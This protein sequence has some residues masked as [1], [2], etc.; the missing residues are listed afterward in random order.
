MEYSEQ[1]C[2]RFGRYAITSTFFGC[3]GEQLYAS[4][5]FFIL[6]M[7]MLG[8]SE[9]TA[10]F[11][12]SLKSW[13]LLLL[14]IP[15]AGLISRIGT[16]LAI[17]V[18]AFVVCGSFVLMA[19]AP[20]VGKY[21]QPLVL[22]GIFTYSLVNIL[23]SGAWYP[24]LSCFLKPAE[25]GSFFGKMR[26]Y[27]MFLNTAFIFVISCILDKKP[28]IWVMQLILLLVGLLYLGRKFCIDRMPSLPP[29]PHRYDLKKSLSISLR[30]TP[31][32]GF[33]FYICFYTLAGSMVIPLS[34][35]YMK[36]SLNFSE[37]TIMLVTTAWMAG[38]ICAYAVVG[39]LMK[40]MGHKWFQVLNHTITVV[41]VIG[42]CCAAPGMRFLVPLM[43]VSTFINGLC[44]AFSTCIFSVEMMASARPGNKVMAMAF[45]TT[46][47]SLGTA[48][49]RT[50]LTLILASGILCDKW[51]L[52]TMLM[53]KYQFL[54]LGVLVMLI[55][56]YLLL[57]LCPS[58]I[59]KH[60]D[61]YRPS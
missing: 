9:S 43:A 41:S 53:D 60:R 56:F 42:F 33:S 50:L 37:S 32:V 29:S 5:S 39:K 21:A 1:E 61:Y 35:L 10:M 18:D 34:V 11:S 38:F 17:A 3:L 49:G 36:T 31:L 15:A 13:A 45:C 20:F 51:M 57:L 58:V 59:S 7:V 25:R 24:V 48:I 47:S 12:T 27:Y 54:L 16:K 44:G 40:V 19:L 2:K 4:N 8:S 28:P 55:F 52:G 26:F 30:N 6:Y 23:Y 22:T 14:M 46:F